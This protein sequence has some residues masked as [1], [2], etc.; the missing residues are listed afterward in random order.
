MR[1]ITRSNRV[2]FAPAA[3]LAVALPVLAGCAGKRVLFP[4]R[5]DL[6]QYGRVGLVTFTVENAKGSLNELATARFSEAALEGQPGIE[7]MELGSA[8]TLLTRL[9][10]T[11]F[12]PAAA[13]AFGE[14]N[15]VPAV[16]VGHLK[17]SNV[18]PSGGLAGFQLPHIEATVTVELSV[19]LLSTETG[20]TRWRASATASEK[21]GQLAIVNG[22][23]VF[24]ARNPNDAYGR[25]VNRLVM[26]VTSDLRPTWGRQ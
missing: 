26:A 16:F 2:R 15:G 4:P 23:P 1:S 12:G 24:S 21:V 7:M 8:D 13:R 6:T 17:V 20:G 22:E 25:L 5:L 14:E 10:E 9:G 3:L 18:K 11:E 19:R